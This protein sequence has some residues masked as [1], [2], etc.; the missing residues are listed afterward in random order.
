MYAYQELLDKFNK[1][2]IPN[3]L[4]FKLENNT[5][6]SRLYGSKLEDK[7]DFTIILH[8][9]AIASI[10][11]DQIVLNSCGFKTNTTKDRMNKILSDN[12]T[13]MKIYQNN[14]KWYIWDYRPGE[15]T[16]YIYQDYITFIH[17]IIYGENKFIDIWNLHN[18]GVDNLGELKILKSKISKYVN[19]YYETFKT[20][21]LDK[22]DL[23]DCLYCQFSLDNTDHLLSHI[24]ENYLVPS[25]LLLACNDKPGAISRM[26]EYILNLWV[27]GKLLE[28]PD[29]INLLNI[30]GDQIKKRLYN[31]LISKL[32]LSG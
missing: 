29:D 21:K 6:V 16:N 20:G 15:K 14:N 17:S 19:L 13:H 24:E 5:Y 10:S 3:K 8:N 25:L 12:N 7:P 27:N 2:S 4:I 22:P 31:Y 1:S 18:T 28:S 9:S 23:G 11:P 26:A 30:V 32:I